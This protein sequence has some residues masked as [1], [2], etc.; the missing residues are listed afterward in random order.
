MST[1]RYWV[2]WL[3]CFFD[4]DRAIQ[5]RLPLPDRDDSEFTRTPSLGN[6]RSQDAADKA[7]EQACRARWRALLLVIKAKLEA[8]EVGI[9]TIE[10]EFLAWTVIPGDGRTVGEAIGPQM[11]RAVDTGETP[12]LLLG[13]AS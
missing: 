13:G 5:F 4:E 2:R 10:H 1:R 12:R 8:V 3:S 9:S 6:Q 11:Q 7:W